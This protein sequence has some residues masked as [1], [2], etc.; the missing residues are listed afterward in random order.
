MDSA[1]FKEI[2]Q[3]LGW[4]QADFASELGTATNSVARWERGEIP[5]PGPVS[6]LAELFA[7]GRVG[8]PRCTGAPRDE[9]HQPILD[10]LCGR[11]DPVVFE[12][13]AADLLRPLY[14]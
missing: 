5:I 6:K 9:H 11:L 1:T 14:P 7:R 13:C 2:R 12:A 10:R 4:S 3:S 8:Q